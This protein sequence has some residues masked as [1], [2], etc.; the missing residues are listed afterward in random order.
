ME[1]I[2]AIRREHDPLSEQLPA[3]IT[4]VFPFDSEL[5]GIELADRVRQAAEPTTAF[6]VTFG[7]VVVHDQTYLFSNISG[8]SDAVVGLHRVL[9]EHLRPLGATLIGTFVPHITVGRLSN[10][11]AA[12]SAA[13]ELACTFLGGATTV[14]TV[15][16]YDIDQ[17]R[18]RAVR[19]SIPLKAPHR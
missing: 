8:G 18:G 15:S 14:S 5:S 16:L 12:D 17:Q 13:V 7:P 3:H 1:A 9:Y 10:R 6:N 4:L 2:E 11:A 19:A